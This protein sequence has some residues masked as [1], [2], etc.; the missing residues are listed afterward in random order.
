MM[1]IIELI[2]LY[3]VFLIV[4]AIFGLIVLLFGTR[5]LFDEIQK[6]NDNAEQSKEIIR[7][8][9]EEWVKKVYNFIDNIINKIRRK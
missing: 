7:R 5:K 8:E 3:I 4:F 6:Q 9:F 1:H 2:I